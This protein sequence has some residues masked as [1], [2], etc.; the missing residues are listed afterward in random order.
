VTL[1]STRH[2]ERKRRHLAVRRDREASLVE[3]PSEHGV[4]NRALIAIEIA[5]QFA[6][7]IAFVGERIATPPQ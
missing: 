1:A 2:G 3:R 6:H 5:E 7:G 4:G